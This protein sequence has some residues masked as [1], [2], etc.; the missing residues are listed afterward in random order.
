LEITEIEE[1]EKLRLYGYDILINRFEPFLRDFIIQEVLLY[2]F[3]ENWRNQIPKKII[4]RIENEHKIDFSKIS[5]EKF[6]QETNLL[7]LKE[8]LKYDK[9]YQF[10]ERIFG[11][12]RKNSYIDIMDELNQ[13]RR[14]VAHAK[15][16]FYKIDLEILINDLKFLL[17]GEA[18]KKIIE[19]I[20]NEKYL[21]IKD[22]SFINLEGKDNQCL[23]NLPSADYDLDGGFVG[24][25][26]EINDVIKLLYS[27]LDRIITITGAGGV[28]KTALALEIAKKIL[29]DP[30]NPFNGIFW[31]SAKEKKLTSDNIELI[32]PDINN[33]EHLIKNLLEIIDK[34][35]ISKF[36]LGKVPI[37]N[38]IEYIYSKFKNENYLLIIDNLESI[39]D[40]SD[41][42]EFI[43]NIPSKVLITSRKGLGKLERP[44]ALKD[45]QEDDA[46]RLFRNV[47]RARNLDSLVKMNNKKI[48]KL[49]KCVKCYPLVIKWSIGQYALGQDLKKAFSQ[50]FVGESN[51]AKFSFE[52]IFSML[53]ENAKLC[54]F[55]IIVWDEPVSKEMLKIL[56]DLTDDLLDDAIRELFITSFIFF[57]EDNLKYDVLSLTKGF[58]ESKLDQNQKIRVML[59]DKKYYLS[60]LIEAD[61]ILQSG[62]YSLPVSL[63][64][65]T[66]E[67]KIAFKYVKKAKEFVILKKDNIRIVELFEQAIHLAPNLAYIYE[68]YSKYEFYQRKNH[69]K[70]LKLAKE[71]IKRAPEDFHFYLNYAI[72]LRK[73][74]K[75]REAI[76]YLIKAL[77]LNPNCLHCMNELGRAYTYIG[78]FKKAETQ[79][80][81][82]EELERDKYKSLKNKMCMIT[83]T[84]KIDNYI[85]WA[86]LF[87]R[88]KN[89]YDALQKL[90]KAELLAKEVLKLNPDDKEIHFSCRSIYFIFGILYKK[91]QDY[92]KALNYFYKTIGII[93]GNTYI[94]NKRNILPR[95]Y[96]E[97]VRIKEKLGI[98]SK[99]EILSLID[100]GLAECSSDS[101]LFKKLKR[102]KTKYI[103]LSD[104]RIYGFIK[105]FNPERKFGIIIANETKYI[106][107]LNNFIERINPS[108]LVEAKGKEVSFHI[109]KS[110]KK[111]QLDV[112][113]NIIIKN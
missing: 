45:M 88:N 7:D 32:Q 44:Y 4:E 61:E 20:N 50:I 106:F 6:F 80:N 102:N 84:F 56:T 76:T 52:N 28:G 29:I 73:I 69:N 26:K 109:R 90:E 67:E 11:N 62:R 104:N 51:I 64:I 30:K 22:F 48:A 65:K 92:K 82:V 96:Y 12:V 103:N 77:E 39:L 110:S 79:L 98:F 25:K 112:A 58:I 1:L 91:K 47:S 68:E 37:D 46:I 101:E 107:F 27:N 93:N 63:N 95:A 111:D 71:G 55:S 21:E 70:A 33:I 41:L 78:E 14:K 15:N 81:K 94:G 9:N 113:E 99:E 85:R 17:R 74:A 16:N 105:Y 86:E 10:V 60:Q 54:L 40:N 3:G 34:D 43:E 97:I 57:T 5:I 49:V 13:I 8:I 72:F 38:Y 59:Q 19:Y 75:P 42:I 108:S 66:P 53:S 18:G 89:F 36:E 23:N 83:K 100:K 31:F 87:I 2:N 24:R 35:C